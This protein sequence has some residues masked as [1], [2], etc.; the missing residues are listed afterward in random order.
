MGYMGQAYAIPLH[1]AGF[2]FNPNIDLIPITS[3]TEPSRN[4]D[5]FEGGVSKRRGTS[6][7]NS[8]VVTGAPRILGLHQFRLNNGTSYKMFGASDGKI[9]KNYTDTIKTGLSASNKYSFAVLNNQVYIAEGSNLPQ[10]WDGATVST[11]DVAAPAAWSAGNRPNQLLPFKRRLWAGVF[12]SSRE[13]AYASAA[14]DG[15]DFSASTIQIPVRFGDGYGL[16]GMA[17]Y[18]GRLIFMGKQKSHILDD[19]DPTPSSWSVFPA[20]W[21]GGVSHWRLIAN[22]YNDL[23]CMMDNGVIYS[24]TTAQKYGDYQMA[25]LTKASYMDRW[26]REN[27]RLSF[28]DDF[29]CSFDPVR[30]IVY[31]FVV[32]AGQTE[33]DTAL[34]FHLDRPLEAAW[35]IDQ[36]TSFASGFGASCSALIETG[37]GNPELYTGD[38]DGFVWKLNQTNKS[39][40]GNGYAS[41]ARTANTSF[42]NPRVRKHYKRGKIIQVPQGS[43]NLN[44]LVYIDGEQKVSTTVSLA[45]TGSVY[46]TGLYGTA[47]Y[48]GDEIIAPTYDINAYGERIQKEFY[49]NVAGQDFFLSQDLTDF[50]VMGAKA[51]SA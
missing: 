10:E 51:K 24:V 18:G 23:L 36:N 32:R 15:G 2:N 21:A 13:D 27:V 25:D 29:H 16:T 42:D 33:V 9:Y 39:D 49:N 1:A 48:G 40:A 31:F 47:V 6:K 7:D 22:V 26:I 30:R 37:T 4:V 38:Y 35:S 19:T 43:Y 20:Q 41:R 34:K 45:G 8:T 14:D 3:L 50:R 11:S 44:V 12:G 46:G 5:L 28:I 17:T